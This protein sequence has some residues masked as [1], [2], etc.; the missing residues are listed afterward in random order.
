MPPGLSNIRIAL[1]AFFLLVLPSFVC[2]A[3]IQHVSGGYPEFIL[4]D[5]TPLYVWNVPLNITI[6]SILS[7]V[8]PTALFMVIQILFSLSPQLLGHKR[9]SYR[10]VL[11]NKNRDEVYICIQDHPGIRM[12]SLSRLMNINIG[13]VRYHVAILCKTGK[14][15]SEQNGKETNYYINGGPLT[16]LEKKIAGNLYNHPKNHIIGF[17]F[18][19]PGCK[20]KD[21]ASALIIS[22]PNL[23]WHMN[24]LIQ[25]D[26]VRH[27]KDGRYIRYYLSPDIE[28]YVNT[29]ASWNPLSSNTQVY[30][31]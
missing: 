3:P 9:V 30:S 16:E 20:R 14:V 25:K 13:T 11:D 7:V 12:R 24:Y 1:T 15:R 28:D 2:A 19:N 4:S 8:V 22:G 31:T 21:I 5:P 27:K 23:T 17:I 29:D 10:N 6:L 26:I 18:Q